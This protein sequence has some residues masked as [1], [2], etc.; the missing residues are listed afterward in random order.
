V[1]RAVLIGECMVELTATPEGLYRRA[2]AGDV[3]NTAV[4]LKRGA[5]EIDVGFATAIGD[6]SLS[7]AMRTA[8]EAA[9]VNLSLTVALPGRSVGLYMIDLDA[10]GER[11]YF[12][13]WRGQ[14]AARFWL[15][16]L[17]G[18]ANA[19]AG[20]DLLHLSGISLAILPP[21]ARPRALA[22]IDGFRS[23]VGRVSF[24]PN[25]RPGLWESEA[26]MRKTTEAMIGRADIVLPSL[27]DGALLWGAADAD[28]VLRRCH[29]AGA[30]EIA[31]TLGADGCL[32]EAGEGAEIRIA[33]P[34]S[35]VV[36]T[37]GAG[38]AFDGAY[39]AARLRGHGPAQ[40]AHAGVALAAR[41]VGL[42]GAVGLA[43]Q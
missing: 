19:I 27:E 36:D 9:G 40:A 14:S 17:E 41:V 32:V 29:A 3:Y 22:F 5:P 2:F 1:T 20:A 15:A 7:Q 16:A 12:S 38:D 39:L 30:R 43:G 37:S 18:A 34:P 8:W 23:R 4:H 42:P 11:R 6:D 24:D 13:Y 31:L 35:E 21:D 26:A 28:I 25:V 33:A 10:A